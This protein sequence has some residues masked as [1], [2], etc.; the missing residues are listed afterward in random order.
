MQQS[1]NTVVTNSLRTYGPRKEA[2]LLISTED[3]EISKTLVW[4][5]KEYDAPETDPEK[6]LPWDIK[7]VGDCRIDD[8]SV[9]I[10]VEGFGQSFMGLRFETSWGV[11]PVEWHV[12][13]EQNKRVWLGLVGPGD[14]ARLVTGGWDEHLPSM[15]MLKLEVTP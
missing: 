5:F 11:T 6:N 2:L 7:D 14:Y 12:H 9:I 10:T 13:A 3:P 4:V 15:R 1:N 8:S